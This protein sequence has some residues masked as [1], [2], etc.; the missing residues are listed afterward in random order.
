VL[1]GGGAWVS[2]TGYRPSRARIA[3]PLYYIWTVCQA[4]NKSFRCKELEREELLLDVR[5]VTRL[6]SD[7][8]AE[9]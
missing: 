3:K 6:L 8:F 9:G 2:G 4:I 7:V 1:R 5:L